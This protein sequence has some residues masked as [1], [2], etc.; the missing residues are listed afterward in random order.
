VTQ[1]THTNIKSLIVVVYCLLS[2][3]IDVRSELYSITVCSFDEC[4]PASEKNETKTLRKTKQNRTK[5]YCLSFVVAVVVVVDVVVA[6]AVV[7]RSIDE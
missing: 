5:C 6:V 4:K 2:L 1:K 7:V 3:P